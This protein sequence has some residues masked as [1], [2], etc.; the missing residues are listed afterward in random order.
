MTQIR[1]LGH[2]DQKKCSN[3]HHFIL[4]GIIPRILTRIAIYSRN[5]QRHARE[6]GLSLS[7]SWGY[8]GLISYYSFSCV[9]VE[10]V[11]GAQWALG[12]AQ[13]ELCAWDTRS[14]TV[15]ANSPLWNLIRALGITKFDF[16]TV[17]RSCDLL[18]WEYQC[19]FRV[20]L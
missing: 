16:S 13:T 3:C 18:I 5:D 14:G 15:I 11:E 1:Q 7:P 2:P 8:C 19:T 12:S 20:K 17:N 4:L 9:D 6:V 10:V